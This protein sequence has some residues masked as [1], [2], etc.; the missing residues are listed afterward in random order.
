MKRLICW[1][2]CSATSPGWIEAIG[3]LIRVDEKKHSEKKKLLEQ[4]KQNCARTN[5]EGFCDTSEQIE[6]DLEE[7]N[8]REDECEVAK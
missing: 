7:M 6:E 3:T 5:A 1:M 2:R 4:F 8:A